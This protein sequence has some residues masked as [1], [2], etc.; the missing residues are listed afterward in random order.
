MNKVIIAGSINQDIVVFAHHHPKI[1]E[2]VFGNNLKY[3]PGGKGA[4]QAIASA[5]LGARTVMLGRVGN[6]TFGEQL[7][8]FL[9]QQNVETQILV[10]KDGPTGTAIITVAGQNSDNT[11]VV[12]PGANFLF[13]AQD[14][15]DVSLEKGDILVSQFEIPIETV[16][17]FFRKGRVAETI[18]VF[19]PAPA[20]IIS[21]SLLDIVDILILNETELSFIS[22]M[23]VDVSSEES[24]KN[25]VQKIK[26]N[27]LIIV[28]TLGERGVIA[29]TDGNIIKVPG[30][31]VKVID[32]TGAGDCFVGA[33]AA[34]M[35]RGKTFTESLVS[36]NIAA[37]ISVTREGAGSSM[38]SLDEVATLI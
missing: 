16:E 8:V 3:F 4:N 22:G 23:L 12:I 25:A 38:P 24:I 34:S 14:I 18:N 11:I 20:Q 31:K 21:Q 6:D 37:S 5:K 36:A 10:E 27:N 29:F 2:T 7:I 15:K 17:A 28:V 26:N 30:R 19:N 1:G 13:T 9:K 33:L 32:T 35:A